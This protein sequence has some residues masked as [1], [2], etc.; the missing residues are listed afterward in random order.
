VVQGEFKT[1]VTLFTALAA[2]AAI[3][4]PTK[5][6]LPTLLQVIMLPGA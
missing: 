2:T 1:V 4:A 5:V 6:M 3:C